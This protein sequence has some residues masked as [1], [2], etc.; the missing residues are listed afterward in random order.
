MKYLLDTCAIS[1]LI[2]PRPNSAVV[3]WIEGCD[4]D[5]IFISV[6][7][8]GEIQ[9]GV[10]KLKNQRRQVKIQQWLDSDLKDRFAERILSIT[11]D[12]A[13][14]WGILEA[15]AES[16]GSPI[17]VI[18]GLIAATAL[19]YNLTVV[20]RNIDDIK[21]SGARVINPWSN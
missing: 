19:S 20:T 16:K 9:K 3:K 11:E 18:E 12:V 5:S 2:K 15:V 4:E 14:T 17:P 13:I 1:E 21:A 6:L 8:L 10:S 7:T